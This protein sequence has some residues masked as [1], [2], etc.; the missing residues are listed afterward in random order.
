MQLYVHVNAQQP[1]RK[2]KAHLKAETSVTLLRCFILQIDKRICGCIVI[3]SILVQCTKYTPGN[4]EQ[5]DKNYNYEHHGVINNAH[6]LFGNPNFFFLYGLSQFGGNSF[7]SY[8][9]AINIADFHMV[10]RYASHQTI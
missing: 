8:S 5:T 10:I 7:H 4:G 3:T 1:S 2:Y 6:L 9:H